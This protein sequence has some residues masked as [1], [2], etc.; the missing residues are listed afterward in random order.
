MLSGG[1]LAGRDGQAHY[2]T[3]SEEPPAAQRQVGTQRPRA[4]LKQG[5]HVSSHVSLGFRG[6]SLIS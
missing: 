3:A 5:L 1:A 6:S 2:R 4:E